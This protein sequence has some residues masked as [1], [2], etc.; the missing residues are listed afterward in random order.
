MIKMKE[1]IAKDMILGD[2]IR[3]YPKSIEVF[4]KHGLHC[5]MCGVAFSET[6]EQ[7]AEAHGIKL[8]TLLTDLNKV[9]NP[10]K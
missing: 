7:A 10:K 9:T 2:V 4:M 5:A 6:I 8:K 3:K 1:K